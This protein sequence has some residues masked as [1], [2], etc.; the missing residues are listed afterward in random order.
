MAAAFGVEGEPFGELE[1]LAVEEPVSVADGEVV[2]ASTS[3]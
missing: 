1:G 3:F 2:V